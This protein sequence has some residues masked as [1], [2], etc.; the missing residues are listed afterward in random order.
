MNAC[1]RLWSKIAR[2]IEAE[3]VGIGFIRAKCRD[4][5]GPSVKTVL[6][7]LK[8]IN[9]HLPVILLS[10]IGSA[11]R[12]YLRVESKRTR[13]PREPHSRW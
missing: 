10:S 12:S 3:G 6:M 7:V 5:F 11:E 4:P 13:R 2:S 1:G 8:V 9:V